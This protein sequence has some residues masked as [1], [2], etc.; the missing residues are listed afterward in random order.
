MQSNLSLRRTSPGRNAGARY[1]CQHAFAPCPVQCELDAVLAVRLAWS[2]LEQLA[3]AMACAEPPVQLGLAPE[4]SFAMPARKSCALL[5]ATVTTILGACGEDSATASTLNSRATSVQMFEWSWN[6]IATECTQWLGPQGYGGVQISPPEAS[7]VS[8]SWWGVYQPV[9]YTQF[10][11]RFG[12]EAELKSMIEACHAAGVRVYADVVFNQMAGGSGTATDGSTW[13]SSSLTYPYFSSNDFHADCDIASSDYNSASTR[14]NVTNCR[15]NDMPDLDTESS[16]V[17]GQVETYLRTLLNMGVD[18][19]R[20]DAAKHIASS[21]LQAILSAVK[22]TNATTNLGESIWITQEVIPDGGVTRSDYYGIGTLN[23]FQFTYAMRDIFRGDDG[24]SLASIPSVMGTWG[25]WGG[26]WYFIPSEDAVVFVNNWDTERDDSLTAANHVTGATNDEDGTYRYSLANIFMLTQ[27]YGDVQVF[28]GFNFTDVDADRPTASPY[29]NGV[30]QIN[31]DWQ[32]VH[33]WPQ[34]SNMVKFRAAMEGQAQ[35]NWAQ[36]DNDNEISFNRGSI[37]F[38]AINNSTSSWIQTFSTH[39]PAGTY[40]NVVQ[41][42]LN[43]AKNTCTGGTVTVDSSGNATLSI[44][45][46]DGSSGVPAVVIYTS[47]KLS[48]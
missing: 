21:S 44:G 37:G 22:S 39:L 25:L 24:L 17:Q 19:F 11:S 38:V 1:H 36:G 3:L 45:P 9:N 4:R 43:S 7:L 8:T 13:D 5:L 18:G 16:Y 10:T 47:Q 34:I 29:S 23:E 14:N 31:K 32:F 28:S 12:T 33:R 6:D 35:Q 27:G 30:A 40:C 42:T 20:I 48:G 26:S 46:N 15:L 2:G 41:G